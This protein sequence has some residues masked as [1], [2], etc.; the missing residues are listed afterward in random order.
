MSAQPLLCDPAEKAA[1]EARNGVNQLEY[2]TQLVEAGATRVGESHVLQLHMLAIEDIYGCGGRYR[3]ARMT[4]KITNS[5]HTV[6]EAAFVPTHV[7]DALDWINEGL[8][9]K[10]S[11]L[12]RAA[13]ALWRLNWIHPF[14]GGNGRTSRALA[15]L[16]LCMDRGYML[17]GVPSMP[18]LIYDHRDEYIRALQAVD[19]S[20]KDD[21]EKLA[22]DAMRDFLRQ[23]LVRQLATVVDQLA[24][25][26]GST[27]N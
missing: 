8:S 16:I 1:L 4:V 22:L 6:P 13:Y 26:A 3:D 23:M 21:D 24:S 18:S 27:V 10:I 5:P 12:E 25:P 11:A 19:S 9:R 15:Y 20:V 14:A 17:P 2:I 7:R